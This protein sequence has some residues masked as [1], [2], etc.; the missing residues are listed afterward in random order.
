M[1]ASPLSVAG[2]RASLRF[3]T[4]QDWLASLKAYLAVAIALAV[5]FSQN[6]DNPYW[7]A[8]TIYVLSAQPQSGAMRS[9]A[10]FRLVGTLFGGCM[11][12]ALAGVFGDDLGA[13]LTAL[14]VFVFGSLYLQQLDK[15]PSAYLWFASGLTAAVI[16]IVHLQA[17]QDLFLYATARMGE[18][19]LA[20]VA[21]TVVDAVLWPAAMTPPFLKAMEQWR[22]KA[23]DWMGSALNA[24]EQP[25]DADQRWAR[26]QALRTLTAQLA[27]IDAAMVQLPY[28][29]VATPAR[30]RDIWALR[31]VV[32]DLIAEF[33]VV[34]VWRRSLARLEIP[35]A[36]TL[37]ALK[38]AQGWIE[39]GRGEGE[40]RGDHAA[41]GYAMVK[42]IFAQDRA[43][44][45]ADG[46]SD[47]AEAAALAR[48][49][50][51]VRGWADLDLVLS[52]METRGRLP[53]RL[54]QAGRRR[55]AHT[56][57]YVT[58][59]LDLAPMALA[60]LTASA[61]WYFTAWSAGLNALLFAFLGCFF[62]IGQPASLRNSVGLLIL[63]VLAFAFTF[64]YL[65]AVLPRVTA[66][67]V[68]IGVLGVFLIP[69]G[70]LSTMS[71]AGLMIGANCF[72][73]MGLQNAYQADFGQSLLTLTGSLAGLFIAL[74]SRYACSYDRSRFVARRL[75]RAVR[76]DVADAALTKRPPS[77]Q[78]FLS[79]SVDR[80]AALFTVLDGLDRKD[81]LNKV[82]L[83]FDFRVGANLLTLRQDE[84]RLGP[85]A[86][87]A[88][89]ALRRAVGLSFRAYAKGGE[90]P[91]DLL[92]YVDRCL[93]AVL[94]TPGAPQRDRI[95]L[96]LTG[97]R[98]TLQPDASLPAPQDPQAPA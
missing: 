73:F 96:G 92:P 16:G 83:I 49:A 37:Q 22:D 26:R 66:F 24:P 97:L 13:L 59:L 44:L 76:M 56:V 20:I 88:A 60:M 10:L 69:I 48:L 12:M 51:L 30:R 63:V 53:D 15:T 17:P 86:A 78:R 32:A 5:G 27:P 35:A 52:A 14:A 64:L 25:L 42:E 70:L 21:L 95:L 71:L 75:V 8:L 2:I 85:E 68:L 29:I 54:A 87:A 80:L 6:L 74:G 40:V 89:A 9:K 50:D 28:D 93:D 7:S 91:K 67:P 65:F 47:R 58:P 94:A 77:R 36:E 45:S 41:R 1:T 11:A 57:D 23:R 79:L 18:I 82:D 19:S 3:P 39:E 34:G 31:S 98:L 72:A 55:P 46:T 84:Q 43:L 62:L 90:T 38:A 81:P 4:V 61:L 33:A